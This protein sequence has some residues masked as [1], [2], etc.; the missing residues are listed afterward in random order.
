[1]NRPTDLET[2]QDY[3]VGTICGAGISEMISYYF[4]VLINYF[5]HIIIIM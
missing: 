4:F 1:M 2:I 5:I 3:W